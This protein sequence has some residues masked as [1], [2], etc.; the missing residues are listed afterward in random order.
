MVAYR[1]H[2]ERANLEA[3]EVARSGR[4]G[5]PR[6]FNSTF[7]TPVVPGNIRVRRDTGGGVLYDIG[8]YCINA[9]RYLFGDE[10]VEVR[11]ACA[12]T[13][14]EVEESVSAIAA[15]PERAPGHVHRELRR[16]QGLRVPARRHQ[17]RPRGR[18]R[19]R[20]RAPAAPPPDARRRDARAALRQ[21]RPVRARAALLLRLHPAEPRARAR[22]RRGPRRR[23]RDP[24][25]VP[26]GGERPAGAPG[27]VRQARAA[28]P[29]AGDP[30]S[31]DRQARG[32]PRRSPLGRRLI[33][34]NPK[35]Q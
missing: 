12:G 17:G 8:I 18:A 6:L 14:D 34:F 35:E 15:L 22:R 20:L 9:A 29:R 24:R 13:L 11:A 23:A 25:A 19:L 16:R 10:P 33:S 5:E 30:P 28:E 21:A 4:I 32:D 7:C 1:L 26:L 3:G 2:F 27:A 31:P